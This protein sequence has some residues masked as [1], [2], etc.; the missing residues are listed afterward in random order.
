MKILKVSFSNINSL[1]GE[2]EIDFTHET[3]STAGIFLITGPTGSGKTT[4]M[5]AIC[6][7]LYGMT[8][9]QTTPISETKN[10]IMTRGAKD[11][12]AEVWF[13]HGDKRYH[14]QAWQQISMGNKPF[15]KFYHTVAELLPNGQRNIIERRHG[16]HKSTQVEE[17]TGISFDNFKRCIMLAQGE[18]DAFLKA[19]I[20][21]K[22][23]A[24]EAITGTEIYGKIGEKAAEKRTALE[25]ELKK[26][27]IADSISEEEYQALLQQVE[28]TQKEYK[29]ELDLLST[30]K[31]DIERMVQIEKCRKRIIDN[32]RNHDKA[33]QDI[34]QFREEGLLDILSRGEKASRV[35]P[36]FTAAQQARLTFKNSEQKRPDIQDAL[37]N[38]EQ[39]LARISREHQTTMADLEARHKRNAARRS[40]LT[41]EML[42]QEK[43][44]Q[45]QQ[46]TAKYKKQLADKT[47]A[48]LAAEQTQ[49]REAAKELQSISNEL[50]K[51]TAELEEYQD[52]EA[53]IE[54]LPRL[55]LLLEKWEQVDTQRAALPAHEVLLQQRDN[56]QNALNAILGGK[57]AEAWKNHYSHLRTLHDNVKTLEETLR[58]LNE[59]QEEAAGIRAE[60]AKLPDIK[61]LQQTAA[62]LQDKA[63]NIRKLLSIEDQLSVI[64][65]E[66]V[67]G[68]Y[69]TCPCCG[70]PT[71]G[72]RH[73]WKNAEWEQVEEEAKKARQT[74][75]AA[76]QKHTKL[77]QQL[78]VAETDCNHLREQSQRQ[79][80]MVTECLQTCRLE[81]VPQDLAET[82]S[83]MAEQTP[84]VDNLEHQLEQLQQ[85]LQISELRMDFINELPRTA[86]VPDS[87]VKAN[88]LLKKL[89][90]RVNT[91]SKTAQRIQQQKQ[92]LAAKQTEHTQA[93]NRVTTAQSDAEQARKESNEALAT[94]QNTLAQFNQQWGEGN[95]YARLLACCDADKNSIDTAIHQADAT[96]AK[97]KQTREKAQTALT[98]HDDQMNE[99]LREKEKQELALTAAL[100]QE[101]FADEAEYTAAAACIERVD[102]L[103]R[104][105]AQLE[106]NKATTQTALE[107]EQKHLKELVQNIDFDPNV[108]L[109]TLRERKMKQEEQIDV[110][111]KDL[112]EL[113]IQQRAVESTRAQ[114][115]TNQAQRDRISQELKL[116][117][118]L[119]QVLGEAKDS[120][121]RYAQ[122]ITF[123]SL[124]YHANCELQQLSTRYRLIRTSTQ[125]NALGLSVIDNQLGDNILRDSSN[126]SGGERFIVSL[127]LALGL[128]RMA[129]HTGIDTL[130][131][132]EGFGT[133]DED[134]LQQVVSCLE[135]MRANGKLVGIITH[136]QKL[137]ERIADKLEVQPVEDGYSTIKNHPAV[138]QNKFI[139]PL[140]RQEEKQKKSS[141]PK[142]SA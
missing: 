62:L 101:N 112:Q 123:D 7:A 26:Y 80:Q 110:L 55:T 78:L 117:A 11:F 60:L 21:E 5:D 34:Q 79:H 29:T 12:Y 53:L 96:L 30:M 45:E 111:N 32:T 56:T 72:N 9:R 15:G 1:A 58:R 121:K 6:L 13:T 64:Y 47:S 17:V 76:Q 59:K 116:W 87:L 41:D 24:L 65:R 44:L 83:S 94:L 23:A 67:A 108:C 120:F 68:K 89:R 48:T 69:E 54:K 142:K 74:A 141:K 134:T 103:R 119:Y 99:A 31:A 114:N 129:S 66:F 98:Q 71:P 27:P 92:T 90:D 106:L 91:Y 50:D 10:E 3:L 107:E 131:M 39:E 35:Q 75:D 51:S 81:N 19:G 140:V 57:D 130:F 139:H 4:I 18:F 104:H 20:N 105:R 61:E 40:R 14:C 52:A 102:D 73:V 8:P 84:V 126:L 113:R 37:N 33:E 42:P 100:A 16:A 118:D 135:S 122:Q 132:D 82:V 88:S 28:Q 115:A 137:S 127:S 38:A 43:Q 136:V 133:L 109:N 85:Q 63:D 95:T 46:T 36:A 2:Y 128:S 70:S 86:E 93:E 22:S 97:A 77:Q 138:L 25:S 125:K 124:I 49:L